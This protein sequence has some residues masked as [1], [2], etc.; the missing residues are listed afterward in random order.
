[1]ILNRLQT[2][3]VVLAAAGAAM[4]V[5]LGAQ[6]QTAA[7]AAWP[8]KPIRW[9]VPYPPGGPS[10]MVARLLGSKLAERIGQA[11]IIENRPGGAGNIGVEYVMKAAP[12]GHAIV[13]AV[14]GIILNPFIVKSS[15]DY[16]DLAPVIQIAN[17]SWV[18]IAS[19]GFAPKTVAEVIALAKAKPGT[20]SCGSSGGLPTVAC[21]WLR[22]YAR[23]EMIMVMYKGQGPA[24]N[25]LMGGEINLLFDGVSTAA[26]QVKAGRVR[27]LASLNS[28]RGGEV[29][30]DLPT[31]A[32]T[33]PGFELVTFHGVMAPAATPRDIIARLNRE[34]AAVLAQPD[35]RRRL[36]DTGFEV[37]ASSVEA[38]DDVLRRD[39]AKYGKILKE[40][41]IKPE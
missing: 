35:I 39:S 38:F 15:P 5:A 6:A 33:I 17:A 26:A 29:F 10:D 41:G 32:E 16:R 4:L 14:P 19:T 13:Y 23:A 40:A 24:L 30:A 2:I 11:V 28:R 12:D 36:T 25:A 18:L 22:S 37:V 31:M 21:E 7:G 1:M 8:S 27:P 34:F 3:R 9:V 20:V